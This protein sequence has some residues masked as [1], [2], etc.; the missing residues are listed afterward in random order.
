MRLLVRW[1][2]LLLVAGWLLASCGALPPPE[3]ATPGANPAAR[4]AAIAQGCAR[5]ASCAH[6]HDPP[7]FRDPAAC[8]DHWVASEPGNSDPLAR[9]LGS[10]SSCDAIDACLHSAPHPP[11]TAFCLAH[12][13]AMTGCDGSHAILCSE[14]DPDESTLVDCAAFGA[15]C[16]ALTQAGGLSTHACVD[17]SRCPAELTKS[18]CDRAG[19]VFSC[20]DGEI[21]RSACAPGESC[22]AHV[23][24]DGDQA[25][26]C[27]APGHA[28]CETPGSRRCEGSRLVRCEAHG[29]FGHERSIDCHDLGL[30]CTSGQGGARCTVGVPE[31]AGGQATCEGNALSFCAAGQ[32]LRVDCGALGLSTCEA[33]GRGPQALCRPKKAP[34]GL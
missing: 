20:H 18:W 1:S 29:H 6:T 19:A 4:F 24:R 9:C 34:A 5:I 14:D 3:A 7:Y 28:G 25:A 27:E 16:L 12:P 17:P 33:D 15:K 8:V 32:R 23:E 10:A 11:A 26:M 21:E 22:Q 31:C 13:G 30:V 2:A